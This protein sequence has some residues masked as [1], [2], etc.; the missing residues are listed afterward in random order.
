MIGNHQTLKFIFFKPTPIGFGSSRRAGVMGFLVGKVLET[1]ETPGSPRHRI[2][3][4]TD[5]VIQRKG[6]TSES[7]EIKNNSISKK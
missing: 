2:I 4:K 7:S 1:P 6:F 3:P 5:V